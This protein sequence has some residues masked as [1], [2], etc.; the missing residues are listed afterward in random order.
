MFSLV[1][2]ISEFISQVFRAPCY[3]KRVG[4]ALLKV[5]CSFAVVWEGLF[6]RLLI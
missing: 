6:A 1:D 3:F 5:L 4:A 2:L